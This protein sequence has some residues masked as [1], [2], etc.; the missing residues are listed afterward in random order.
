MESP[1]PMYDAHVRPIKFGEGGG[2]SGLKSY[3][4][5]IEGKNSEAF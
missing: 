5:E 1:A 2:V 4:G 3:S